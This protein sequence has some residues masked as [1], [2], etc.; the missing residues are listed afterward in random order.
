MD[1]ALPSEAPVVNVKSTVCQDVDA[2]I[3][4]TGVDVPVSD[5]PI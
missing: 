5:K 3:V 2:G 4:L 1:G